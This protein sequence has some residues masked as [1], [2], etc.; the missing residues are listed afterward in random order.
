MSIIKLVPKTE[1][2]INEWTKAVIKHLTSTIDTIKETENATGIAVCITHS[3]GSVSTF[4]SAA[5]YF[6]M[7]GGLDQLK[8][9]MLSEA[10]GSEETA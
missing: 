9:E 2:Q 8:Y 4:Y 10:N 1:K 6:H 3:D 5:D 7:C